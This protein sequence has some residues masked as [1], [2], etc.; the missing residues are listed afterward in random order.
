MSVGNAHTEGRHRARAD[1][2]RTGPEVAEVLRDMREQRLEEHHET[3][4]SGYL[5]EQLGRVPESGEV[6]QCH[7]WD[8][9][10]QAVEETR[11]VSLTVLSAVDQAH[12]DT[13]PSGTA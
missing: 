12:G 11:I 9:E 13:R 2:A 3:T 1:H 10:I 7:G 8:I 5:S 4:V 6:V